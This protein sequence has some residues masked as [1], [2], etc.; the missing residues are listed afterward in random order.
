VIRT[1]VFPDVPVLVLDESAFFRRTVR[2]MLEQANIRRV[3]EAADVREAVVHLARVKP[4]VIIMD[5]EPRSAVLLEMLRDPRRSTQTSVPVIV[6][7]A[8]PTQRMVE[9]AVRHDVDAVLRKP[10]APK[11]LWQRLGRLFAI[12]GR[13]AQVLDEPLPALA[14]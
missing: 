13:P 11:S 8:T 7:S 5:W 12:E 4:A 3:I 9:A 10:F 14:Q 6:T 2:A 1:P